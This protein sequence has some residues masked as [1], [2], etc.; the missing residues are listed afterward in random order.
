MDY[1][2]RVSATN[3]YQKASKNLSIKNQTITSEKTVE[4][5]TSGERGAGG[6]K[7]LNTDLF[8]YKLNK[9]VKN[10]KSK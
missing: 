3:R 4:V 10:S 9:K 2:V 7:S 6:W 5:A 1:S 8:E